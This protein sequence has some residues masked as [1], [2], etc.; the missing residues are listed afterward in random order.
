MPRGTAWEAPAGF[1]ALPA[2]TGDALVPDDGAGGS[3]S[4]TARRVG[5]GDGDALVKPARPART[6]I[7]RHAD[8]VRAVRMSLE[9]AGARSPE[10]TSTTAVGAPCASG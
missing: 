8:D 7:E 2:L 9:N 10:A 3:F 4:K 1:S 5:E 6:V